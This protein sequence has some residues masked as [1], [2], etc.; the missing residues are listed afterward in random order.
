MPAGYLEGSEVA[1]LF[2]TVFPLSCIVLSYERC[3]SETNCY[4]QVSYP[5]KIVASDGKHQQAVS[6]SCSV[7]RHYDEGLQAQAICLSLGLWFAFLFFFTMWCCSK[8]Q[9]NERQEQP[10][11]SGLSWAARE[12][13]HPNKTELEIKNKKTWPGDLWTMIQH[14]TNCMA[15]MF[16]IKKHKH[17]QTERRAKSIAMIRTTLIPNPFCSLHMLRWFRETALRK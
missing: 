2:K 14:N 10:I 16:P 11:P 5:R 15:N 8:V 13:G 3:L 17:R 12:H 7:R 1:S 9:W 6:Y 4:S